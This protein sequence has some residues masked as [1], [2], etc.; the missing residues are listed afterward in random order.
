MEGLK[1]ILSLGEV[2]IFSGTTFY[3][4]ILMAIVL[5]SLLTFIIGISILD[6][7][8]FWVETTR[9]SEIALHSWTTKIK[10]KNERPH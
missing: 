7:S 5:H 10:I 2:W 1:T 3:E 9:L 8:Q 4:I 6:Q